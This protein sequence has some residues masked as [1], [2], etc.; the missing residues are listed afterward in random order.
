MIQALARTEAFRKAQRIQAQ[1]R[2]ELR[3]RGDAKIIGQLPGAAAYFEHAAVEGDLLAQLA[4]IDAG[5]R[6]FD[7]G[8]RGVA[9][10]IARERV[11]FVEALHHLGDVAVERCVRLEHLP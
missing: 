3:A 5:A 11:G 1:V 4:R 6:L 7:H 9:R 8:L 2:T 10:V